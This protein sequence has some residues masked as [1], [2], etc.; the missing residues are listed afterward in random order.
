MSN[1]PNRS[2]APSRGRSPSPAEI[3]AAREACGLTQTQAA[4][5]VH[6]TLR[7][8]QRWEAGDWPMHPAF[9]DLFNIK[10]TQD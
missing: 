3:K 2:R 6:V 9:W 8:W 5:L 10:K 1:H 7:A 4:T